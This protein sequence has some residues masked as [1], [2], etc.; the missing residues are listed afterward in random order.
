MEGLFDQLEKLDM[1]IG[2][3]EKTDAAIDDKIEYYKGPFNDI[4]MKLQTKELLL[5]APC[6]LAPCIFVKN[7]FIFK[8]QM[9]NLRSIWEELDK[10]RAK[11]F[12]NIMKIIKE[13]DRVAKLKRDKEK[14]EKE[15]KIEELKKKREKEGGK[16]E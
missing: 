10:N 4:L 1:N 9:R 7:P 16:R 3:K 12:E 5:S 15:R 13:E 2:E 11:K 14:K 8:T 6:G